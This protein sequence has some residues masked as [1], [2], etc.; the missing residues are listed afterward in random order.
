MFWEKGRKKEEKNMKRILHAGEKFRVSCNPIHNSLV[1]FIDEMNQY[2]GKIVTIAKVVCRKKR[3]Y[4]IKEDGSNW[5]WWGCWLES[6]RAK[7]RD[8]KK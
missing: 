7:K 5:I 4:R 8:A 1:I 3:F 6:L 2:K